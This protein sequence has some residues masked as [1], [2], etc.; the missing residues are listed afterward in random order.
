MINPQV[1]EAIK[2]M[3]IDMADS[4]YR[5]LKEIIASYDKSDPETFLVDVGEALRFV[6]SGGGVESMEQQ[7]QQGLQQFQESAGIPAQP[8][9]TNS[10]VAPNVAFQPEPG[11]EVPIAEGQPTAQAI[12]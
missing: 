5:T 4:S 7:I 10:N 12:S 2:D 1:P 6:K 11:S 3:I 8:G 9:A